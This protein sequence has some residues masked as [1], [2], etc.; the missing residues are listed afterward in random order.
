[1]SQP[2][3]PTSV[4]ALVELQRRSIAAERRA[5][6]LFLRARLDG[7]DRYAELLDAIEAG[8]H[9]NEFPPKET[10]CPQPTHPFKRP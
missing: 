7:A 2:T 1:M 4:N 3:A 10:L 9:M 8:A 6:V 5:I